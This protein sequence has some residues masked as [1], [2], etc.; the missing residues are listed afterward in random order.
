MAAAPGTTALIV[1]E[2]LHV[3]EVSL[4]LESLLVSLSKEAVQWGLDQIQNV[5]PAAVRRDVSWWELQ[6]QTQGICGEDWARVQIC[7]PGKGE[8]WLVLKS[9]TTLRRY[10]ATVT[11]SDRGPRQTTRTITETLPKTMPYLY[12]LAIYWSQLLPLLC[13]Y[14]VAPIWHIGELN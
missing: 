13:Q 10:A 6:C 8:D 9:W 5:Q 12:P 7:A 2:R 1:Y 11:S 14:W 3:T 4:H